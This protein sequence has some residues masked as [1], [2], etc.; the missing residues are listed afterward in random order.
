MVYCQYKDE[1][2]CR[3][4]RQ[5]YYGEETGKPIFCGPHNE[6]KWDNVVS[7]RCQHPDCGKFASCGPEGTRNLLYC[8]PHGKEK[9]MSDV[10]NSRCQHPDCDK[11]ANWGPEDTKEKKYCAQHGRELGMDDVKHP[12]CKCGK[13]IWKARRESGMLQRLQGDWNGECQEPDVRGRRVR[14]NTQLW[15]RRRTGDLL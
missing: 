13:S 9:G 6:K 3:C 14:D 11:L 15:P 1:H 10:V 7:P 12:K 2:G 5:P 4:T 8:C